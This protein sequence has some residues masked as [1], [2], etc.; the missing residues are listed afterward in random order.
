[1]SRRPMHHESRLLRL[2][3]IGFLLGV[4]C[5]ALLF[6]GCALKVGVGVAAVADLHSTRVALGAGGVEGNPLMGQ[7]AVRQAIVKAIGATGVI[8]LAELINAK[9]HPTLSKWVQSVVIVAW[10][11]ASAWNY[12]MAVTR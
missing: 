3:A 12:S 5:L 1:M 10:S 8:G 6:S 9:G 2:A 7:G 4:I 11:A